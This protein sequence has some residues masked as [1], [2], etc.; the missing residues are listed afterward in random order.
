MSLLTRYLVTRFL[1][2]LGQVAGGLLGIYLVVDLFE[3]IDDF[4][5]AGQPL[6]MA[7]AFFVLRLPA[8]AEELLPVVVLLSGVLVCGLLVRNR[9]WLALQA[10][11]IGL[12]RIL[13][14]VFLAALLVTLAGAVSA[15]WL[16]PACNRAANR[17]WHEL[18]RQEE[19]TGVVRAGRTFF[20]GQ[21]G[22]YTFIQPGV[23]TDRLQDFV[24]L[25]WDEEMAPRLLVSAAVARWT[26]A[27]WQLEGGL[28]KER[29]PEGGF[30]TAFAP[31][32]PVALP[33][34]PAEFF[35]PGYRR[36]ELSLTDLL[37]RARASGTR[38]REAWQ[39]VQSRLSYLLLGL[40]LLALG[41]P[42][43]LAVA[44]RWGRDL[45][46]AVPLSA[47]LA[48][49]AWGAWGTGQALARAGDLPATVAAWGLHLLLAGL[50]LAWLRQ[51]NR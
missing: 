8:V 33:E 10:A 22:I 31:V 23:D 15:Q 6:S 5:E 40:P 19:H 30:R 46:L 50:G 9:E 45:S 35:E 39:D 28:V 36:E 29:T 17:I 18:V 13:A 47:A 24:Y 51:Q 14:P 34:S 3:K 44:R 16:Q 4:L 41:L 21:Q 12:P 48:F 2:L 11:G 49:L 7:A 20:R 26:P 38:A 42:A 25:E 37:A 1:A 32:D 43:F 27:G